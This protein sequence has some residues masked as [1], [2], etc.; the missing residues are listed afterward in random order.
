MGG[1]RGLSGTRPQ[2]IELNQ[3]QFFVE[4]STDLRNA[5]QLRWRIQSDT[6]LPP[7]ISLGEAA[8][9]SVSVFDALID[10]YVALCERT[11]DMIIRH[12]TA[13]VEHDLKHHLTRYEIM[14][15]I[16]LAQADGSSL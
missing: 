6:L 9:G 3:I 5:P 2:E 1:R 15:P 13:E 8:D 11:E 14:Y 10:R 16:R 12:I 7:S 4:M